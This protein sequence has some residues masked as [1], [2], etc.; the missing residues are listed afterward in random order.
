MGSDLGAP[1]QERTEP[2]AGPPTAPGFLS[3]SADA[4]AGA[5]L[6]GRCVLKIGKPFFISFEF[7][8]EKNITSSNLK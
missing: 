2:C 6:F 1:P 7:V 8:E 5:P 4:L 3:I